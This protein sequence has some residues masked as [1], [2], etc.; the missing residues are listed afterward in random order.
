MK[1]TKI[2]K[3]EGERFRKLF[4][5]DENLMVSNYGRLYDTTAQEIIEPKIE[6]DYKTYNLARWNYKYG[7]VSEYE[8]ALMRWT[9]EDIKIKNLKNK[10]GWLNGK[11]DTKP[12]SIMDKLMSLFGLF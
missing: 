7:T 2:R 3:K 4:K 8:L 6:Y 9:D 11:K 12:E 10:T 5:V 1:K